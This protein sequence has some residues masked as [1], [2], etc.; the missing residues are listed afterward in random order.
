MPPPQKWDLGRRSGIWPR[1]LKVPSTS[2]FSGSTQIFSSPE[3]PRQSARSE[4]IF[5]CHPHEAQKCVW[6]PESRGN[7]STS[8]EIGLGRALVLHESARRSTDS[9][10]PE[11]KMAW[12]RP[13]SEPIAAVHLQNCG[14]VEP[15]VLGIVIGLV[16]ISVAGLFVAAIGNWALSVRLMLLLTVCLY[17]TPRVIQN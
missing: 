1:G 16:C 2:V 11:A 6:R 8:E 12:P 4:K 14:M 9:R 13:R 5:R 10:G 15:I 7:I 17:Y 3:L